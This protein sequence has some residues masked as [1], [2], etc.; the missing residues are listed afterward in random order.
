MAGKALGF[1]TVSSFFESW[2]NSCSEPLLIHAF[3]PCQGMPRAVAEGETQE[4]RK[5]LSHQHGRGHWT[6]LSFHD[7]ITGGQWQGC[8]CLQTEQTS[9]CMKYPGSMGVED[10]AD[11]EAFQAKQAQYQREVQMRVD[12]G[13]VSLWHGV[14]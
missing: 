7:G 2:K 14:A 8:G 6:E 3:S 5:I 12:K 13:K 11:W 1:S 4:L 9:W 10:K